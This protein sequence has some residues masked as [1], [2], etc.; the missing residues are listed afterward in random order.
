MHWTLIH[1]EH[2]L[3]V[4]VLSLFCIKLPT[5]GCITLLLAISTVGVNKTCKQIGKKTKL[6]VYQQILYVSS[7][8]ENVVTVVSKE[9]VIISEM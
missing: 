4:K 7:H 8:R 9:T 5:K 1:I 3:L 2:P 6:I